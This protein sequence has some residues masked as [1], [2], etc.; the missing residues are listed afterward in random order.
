[1]VGRVQRHVLRD[2]T[3]ARIAGG[4]EQAREQRGGAKRNGE[5]MFAAAGPNQKNIHVRPFTEPLV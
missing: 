1:M 4:G 5:R 2:L 3:N